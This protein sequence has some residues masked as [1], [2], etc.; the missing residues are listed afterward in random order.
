MAKA[1]TMKEL[2]L[3]I[4]KLNNL[5]VGKEKLLEYLEEDLIKIKG[6]FEVLAEAFCDAMEAIADSEDEKAIKKI[7]KALQK[8]N[9]QLVDQLEEEGEEEE[10][11]DNGGEDEDEDEGEEE[12]EDEDEDED[13]DEEEEPK[14]GKKKKTKKDKK[15][16]KKKS[17]EVKFTREEAVGKVFL[18]GGTPERL[19]ELA[20]AL[21]TKKTGEEPNARQTQAR[22]TRAINYFKG[23]GI[24]EVNE[25][26]GKYS[27]DL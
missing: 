17:K 22:V 20:D 7:P 27:L 26:T 2:K 11:E 19:T 1:I 4:G 8:F 9:D 18:K 23:A 21:Y 3:M 13:E 6:K 25:K 10:D 16:K 15:A 14:K 24:L 5:K 12:E